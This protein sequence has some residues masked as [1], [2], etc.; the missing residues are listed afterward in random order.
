MS[1]YSG[2][3]TYNASKNFKLTDFTLVKQDLMNYFNIRKGEKLMNPSFGTIIWNALFEPFD[4]NTKGA[5]MNDIKS[6]IAYDPRIATDNVIITQYD[7]GLQI[8]INLIYVATD[9][10]STLALQFDQRSQKITQLL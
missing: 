6:I 10:R 2:F 9:E 1:T 3:S 7:Q 8:E 5:I 4:D